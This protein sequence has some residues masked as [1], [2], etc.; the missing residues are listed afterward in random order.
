MSFPAPPLFFFPSLFFSPTHAPCSKN[1][2]N[3]KTTT[4]VLPPVQIRPEG[5][6]APPG[7]PLAMAAEYAGVP[8]G[9][10]VFAQ[11]REGRWLATAADEQ[12]RLLMVDELGDLFYD[13]GDPKLG[14]YAVDARGDVYNFFQDA[15]GER[16]ITPLGNISGL[17]KFKVSEVAGEA[18]DPPAEIA[19]FADRN[20]GRVPLPPN[21]LR[22]GADGRLKGPDELLEGAEV[23][24]DN[25]WERLLGRG[26]EG[27][28]RYLFDRLD[29]DLADAR[30]V[31]K[32]LWEQTLLE[33]PD[34]MPPGGGM[35]L[36]AQ[37][38]AAA[39]RRGGGR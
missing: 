22:V 31:R 29:V 13:S 6:G 32:Q 16:R 34:I 19:A 2:K 35:E 11:T 20:V 28:R 1:N 12:G 24:R 3:Q 38:A 10:F 4:G 26:L 25:P 8:P 37:K 14:M 15:G 36:L 39:A 18:L 17:K 5:Q 30:P 27:E 21:A 9:D 23:P 7:F 33:D